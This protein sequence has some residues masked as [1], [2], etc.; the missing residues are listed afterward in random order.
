MVVGIM[1]IFLHMLVVD[2][3]W[4]WYH[5]NEYIKL[6]KKVKIIF[7]NIIPWRIYKHVKKYFCFVYTGV[8]NIG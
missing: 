7:K 5:E 8:F 1:C 4:F 2:G 6:I 3:D